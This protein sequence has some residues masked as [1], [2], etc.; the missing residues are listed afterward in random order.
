MKKLVYLF[1]SIALISCNK[2]NND[3]TDAPGV[4]TVRIMKYSELGPPPSIEKTSSTIYVKKKILIK[5]ATLKIE[6]SNC[7][8]SIK[9][10]E[11]IVES[12]KGYISQSETTSHEGD[13]KSGE[14]EIKVPADKFDEFIKKIASVGLKILHQSIKVDDETDEYIDVSSRLENKRIL[15]KRYR[16]ILIQ[17]KSVKE[18]LQVEEQIS[19]IREEI[20]SSEKRVKYLESA[21]AMSN[22]SLTIQEPD[23]IEVEKP[24]RWTTILNGFSDGFDLFMKVIAAIITLAIAIIPLIPIAYIIYYFIKKYYKKKQPAKA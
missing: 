16:E 3:K 21:S 15:E 19:L 17:A 2:S 11:K 13:A 23:I 10:I 24:S 1:V 22:I 5:N 12:Y 20:E 9:N 7:D 4:P 18:I 8:E 6:V 14:V